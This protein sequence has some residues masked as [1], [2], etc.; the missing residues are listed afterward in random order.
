MPNST[1]FQHLIYRTAPAEGS[2]PPCQLPMEHPT[3]D[4]DHA[5]GSRKILIIEVRPPRLPGSASH[6]AQC[7][8][9]TLKVGFREREVGFDE[10]EGVHLCCAA[11]L[12][13]HDVGE[14]PVLSAHTHPPLLC[15][16]ETSIPRVSEEISS[17]YLFQYGVLLR[18]CFSEEERAIICFASAAGA[19]EDVCHRCPWCQ[20][21]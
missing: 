8:W 9:V 7:T 2:A 19:G 18:C 1:T 11:L 20:E 21:T 17:F 4:G 10:H 15:R 12:C 3:K 5:N 14:A 6:G 16:S 13:S